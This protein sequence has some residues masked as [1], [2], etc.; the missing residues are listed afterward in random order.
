MSIR[1]EKF[2]V[3]EMTCTSCENRV[4]KACKKVGGVLNA[5]ASYSG[6][7]AEVEYDDELCSIN[8]IKT[9]IKSAGYTTESSNDYKFMGI[10][11]VVAA[12][13]LLG[14]N[15]SG[16]DMEAK[17]KN[18]SYA[19]LFVVGMLT[20]IHCVGMCGGIMLSQSLSKESKNKFEAMEPAILYNIGR[21]VS[22][23]I[24]G[25][26]IGALGSVFT[27]SITAQ[28]GMQIFA[29]VFMI[30]MGFNMAGFSI[31]RKFSI[32]LPHA[33]CKVKNKS[34][35]PFIVGLL[36][37]LMPCGPLQTMQ[38]FAL[39]TGSAVKGALS[40]FMFAIGTVPLMLTFGAISGILSKGYTKKILKFSGVLI[41]VLG[42][43]MGNRGLALTGMS[44]NPLTYISNYLASSD[45]TG[46]TENNKTSSSSSN[47]NKAILKDGVQVLNMTASGRGYTP[48][49][50]YVQKGVPVKWV[51][52]A[53]QLTSCNNAIVI[54][55]LKKQQKLKSG[56]NIIEFT[57]G[58]KD[59]SF[60]CW[61]GMIRGTIKVVDDLGSVAS[62]SSSSSDGPSEQSKPSIYG[63]DIS[64]V[65]TDRLVK[66]AQVSKNNQIIK[67][68]GTGYELEPL[69]VV[70]NKGI[71]TKMSLDLTS[72][73]YYDSDFSIVDANTGAI[74]KE[75][76]GKKGIVDIDFTI[77]SSGVYALLVN[78][79]LL[80][81]V[82]AVDDIKTVNLEEIR[83]K[84]IR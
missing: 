66:K 49:V 69:I 11:I 80:G 21:V 77:N 6:Q 10:L 24:L 74:V 16:F 12:I 35:S 30:M 58:D 48:N 65:P 23:T 61:M 72:F 19:V 51:V 31:F 22:Y 53:T 50:L 36:N 34:G 83:N 8:K 81:V 57:P 55:S 37:G 46:T 82:E 25:G 54:P 56:E 42:L 9:A 62:S 17:L 26:I 28:A 59:L 40:M 39:G 75:F 5:K 45:N 67:I 78:Q 32:K 20:S 71:N 2:K 64:K 60:S 52:N 33:A 41:I 76:T 15:T 18:A 3:Y 4:E 63:N 7:F 44:I 29:A 84:Y 13:V 1:K 43:I 47:A 70:V 73:D 79:D 27:L 38:L 14:I 68:K